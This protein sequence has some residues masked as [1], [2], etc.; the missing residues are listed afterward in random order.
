M[1]L[2]ALFCTITLDD[3]DYTHGIKQAS[4]TGDSF[5][6][7]LKNNLATAGKAAAAGIGMIT[8][9]AGAAVGVLLSLESS[10]EEYRLAM[11]RLNTAFEAAGYGADVAQQAYSAFYGILGDTD[12]ATEASQ[13]LAQLAYNAEDVSVWTN[14]AAGVNG[15]FGD[16]LPIE[17]LI[18]AANETANTATVTGVLADALN[19]V[20]ISEDEFNDRLAECSSESERNRFIMETLAAQYD[21]AADAF[22]R[23]NEA[24]VESRN[25]QAQLDESLSKIGESVTNVR[26]ALFDRLSPAIEDVSDKIAAFISNVDVDALVDGIEGF[27]DAVIANGPTI[28]SIIAG[29]GAGFAAWKVTSLVTSAVTA[30]QSL[31]P[32]LTGAATAQTGLNVA[33][34]ANPIG[35]VITIITSL[36]AVITT[37]WN[38]SEGFRN[39]VEPIWEAVKNVFT[40][41]W[42][43]IKGAWDTAQPYFQA[44]WDAIKAIFTPVADFLGGVFS[45]AWN[46]I[47]GVWDAATGFFENIWNTIEG[48]FSVVESVLSGDFESAWNAIKGVFEGWGNFFSGLWDD[49]IGI[50]SNAWNVFCDI[51]TNI[52]QGIWQGISNAASWLVNKV[53]NFF[54]GIVN[55]VLGF[56]GIHSPSRVFADIGQNMALGVGEGWDSEYGRIRRDIESG[57]DFGTASVDFASSGLGRSQA[58]MSGALSSMAATMGQNFTIT[59]QSVLDGKVIGET[60][61]QYSRGKQRAYSL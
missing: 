20:G 37:L 21:N 41:A 31:I 36:I 24:L 45:T 44:I 12:T 53:K 4:K 17:G 3:S 60:A 9:A 26:N 5:A 50:F 30:I 23:N 40:S 39:A 6:S 1:N 28:L 54:S 48:I 16:S 15:T 10:T 55:S 56:L 27:I 32:A 43:A 49:L 35:L 57:M 51:G 19:W 13:L 59:V 46:A 38:T 22:Y 58:S 25:H 14:I 34:S 47:Q 7:K 2:F 8:A 29:I 33:M 52:V 42:D 61:Y 11:G 18:E